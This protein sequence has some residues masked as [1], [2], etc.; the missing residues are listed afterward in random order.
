MTSDEV[1][2]AGLS[3]TWGYGCSR[4]RESPVWM[5]RSRWKGRSPA[6]RVR[7]GVPGWLEQRRGSIA[8]AVPV[9][10]DRETFMNR[11]LAEP[12][13]RIHDVVV[14]GAGPAG[15]ITA[16]ALARG[17]ASVLLV[18]KSTFP[19]TKVCGCCVNPRALETLRRLGQGQ[20]TARLAA[21]P[22]TSL[23]LGCDGQHATI[24]HPLGVAVSRE[25]F[26]V[27]LVTAAREHGVA[28][29]PATTASL[30]PLASSEFREVRLRCDG[31]SWTVR[32]RFV[33]SATGL[34]DS[35]REDQDACSS[36]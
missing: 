31:G 16:L 12:A 26:D 11:P 17:G 3:L 19:R 18:D 27:A 30:L 24:R 7:A 9:S 22:L 10:D 33:V 4:D 21:V 13:E 6:T 34:T 15:S 23:T 2:W 28:F 8:V 29:L 1:S 32:G 14:V 25:A 20:L 36:N 35:L 5:V